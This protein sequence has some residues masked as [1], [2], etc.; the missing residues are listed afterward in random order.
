MIEDLNCANG[1]FKWSQ[2]LAGK[3]VDVGAGDDP[4]VALGECTP[5]DQNDG[6]ANHL[7]KYFAPESLDFVHASQALEHM[8][9]PAAALDDWLQVVKPGGHV[10]ITIPDF[11]AYEKRHWPSIFN[12]DHKAGFSLWRH[13]FPGVP[14]FYHVPTMLAKYDVKLCRLVMNNY[15]YS[16]PE[17]VDQTY[18]ECDGVECWIEFVIRKA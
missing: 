16:L 5:F 11:D 9:N 8:H 7:S 2:V 3:G 4:L 18:H 1:Q 13:G 17:I 15:N 10:V 14:Q 6:D 12:P